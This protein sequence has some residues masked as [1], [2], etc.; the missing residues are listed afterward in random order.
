MDSSEE[1]AEGGLIVITKVP[2]K[3]KDRVEFNRLSPKSNGGDIPIVEPDY[4]NETTNTVDLLPAK[5]NSVEIIETKWIYA[6]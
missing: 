2:W 4:E 6:R 1:E 3:S 5:F